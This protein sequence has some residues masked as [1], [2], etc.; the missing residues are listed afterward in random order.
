MTDR[1]RQAALRGAAALLGLCAVA[2]GAFSAIPAS[3]RDE[4]RSGWFHVVWETH[5]VENRLASI[6][7]LLV[8][9]RGAATRLALPD[10][11][12]GAAL[13][14]NGKYVSVTGELS[15]VTADGPRLQVRSLRA[16]IAPRLSVSGAPQLGARAYIT[17]LCRFS[18]R[19]TADPNPRATYEQ[20]MGTTYPGLDH[21]WREQSENRVNL[22]G[23]RL[24]GSYV[25]AKP[26]ADYIRTNGQ[27]D[28]Q[29]LITDC[30][31]AADAE[32]DFS[33][34]VGIN[35]QFNS[36]LG[37]ASW[38]GSWT[39][40]LDGVTRRYGVTWMADWATQATYAHELGHSLGLP[41]SS[42]PY[43]A[44]YDSRWDV[45]SGGGSVDAMVGTRVA[46]HTIAFHKDVLGWIP[47]E[48]KY[49]AGPGTA[50]TFT[51]E[52]LASPPSGGY[53]MA[54][55]PIPGTQHFYTVETRRVSGYDASGRLPGEAVVIHRVNLQQESPAR[56][57]DPDNNGNPNDAA[58]QWLPGESFVDAAAQVRV[59]VLEATATGYR[60]EVS[61]L[62]GLA[63]QG[64][65]LRPAALMGTAYSDQL[66]MTG[67]AGSVAWAVSA[68]RLP[69]GLSITSSGA[70]TGVPAEAGSF[71]FTIG[72]V[73]GS[74]FGGRTF[75]LN[76][77]KPQLA[78]ADV[79]GQL[80]GTGGAL[81]ADQLRFLD[82]L[83]NANGRL[84]VGD[85]RAWLVDQGVLADS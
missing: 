31:R 51:L 40:T 8:D 27:A 65:S 6:N 43:S 84:D 28:L 22:S 54:Q 49:V 16:G 48:R 47:A 76:V 12:A 10:G 59:S 35:M 9:E 13:R 73:S 44:T 17:I 83:G 79:T 61:T 46:P 78:Q 58:A 7:Y 67:A 81:T 55:I 1:A 18:D 26:S 64:D 39:L 62:G 85:V 75:T 32:V 23:T 33:A 42:G 3:V 37:G 19:P 2:L 30:T 14:M 82:L 38:G 52:R 24:V 4:T 74:A 72:V 5:G 11:D 41:H 57:V 21:Y 63:V 70:I 34:Y 36:G 68:G 77:A 69:A 56:V 80:F 60:V 71:T 20:W 29:A 53:L 25:L 15:P 66:T 45:M 50:A